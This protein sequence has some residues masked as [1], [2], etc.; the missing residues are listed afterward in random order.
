LGQKGTKIGTR[1]DKWDQVGLTGTKIGCRAGEN[2]NQF[3]DLTLWP[4]RDEV[5]QKK[6][7]TKWDLVG[8]NGTKSDQVGLTELDNRNSLAP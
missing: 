7:G 6:S 1:W 5:G 2:W 4:K 8:L 3:Q